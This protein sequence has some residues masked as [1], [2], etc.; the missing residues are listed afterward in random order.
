M[1]KTNCLYVVSFISASL[2]ITEENS[3][4]SILGKSDTLNSS[5]QNEQYISV[6]K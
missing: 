2:K 6:L 4:S 1:F 5:V 3:K